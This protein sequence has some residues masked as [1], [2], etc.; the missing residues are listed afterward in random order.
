M[1]T[2]TIDRPDRRTFDGEVKRLDV[3]LV[4]GRLNVVGTDGPA[5]I[6]VTAIGAKPI[7]VTL[8]DDGTLTVVHQHPPKWRWALW[9]LFSRTYRADVSVAVPQA[10]PATLNV[11]SGTIV[12][13]TLRA[14]A[15]V[16]VTSGRITLLGLDGRISGRV[17]SGSIEALSIGGELDVETV[18]G[19]IVIADS[20]VARVRAKT[21][22]GSITCDLDNP[23]EHSDVKLETT[24]GE[25]TARVREDSD[26]QVFL[27][28]VSGRVTTAFPELKHEGG[29]A[30]S[31]RLGAGTGQLSASATSGN[32]S[33][34]R[35]PVDYDED[36]D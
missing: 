20:T 6:E 32:I 8:D 30:V 3:H 24:S 35:R 9:W 1:G 14:G 2:W 18:S 16:D 23:P 36:V 19:E 33:L 11:I 10:V 12:A 25:I 17:V 4:Q 28:V 15:R 22:S 26:L 13:S 21:I 34:L 31:G 27:H 29:K 5:R 7:D